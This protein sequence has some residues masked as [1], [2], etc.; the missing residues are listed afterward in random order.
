MDFE[1]RWFAS[2][3][4]AC[5]ASTFKYR[6]VPNKP[7]SGDDIKTHP[8]GSLLLVLFLPL[9]ARLIN[10]SSNGKQCQSFLNFRVKGHLTI[11]SAVFIACISKM[12]FQC[13]K[14]CNINSRFWATTNL[15]NSFT[16]PLQRFSKSLK[17]YWTPFFKSL[18]LLQTCLN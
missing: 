2:S 18:F 6:E 7:F 5:L 4:G 12:Y 14:L 11:L 13:D 10:V 3:D 17:L 1:S 16:A 9:L 15:Q 8:A